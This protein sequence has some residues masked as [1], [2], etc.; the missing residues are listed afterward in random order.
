MPPTTEFTEELRATA[1]AFVS[2]KCNEWITREWDEQGH[3]P[4]SLFEE[5]ASLGWFGI[6]VAEEDGGSGGTAL[7]LIVVCE[8]L[9]RGST[10]LVACLS[11]T[12]SGLRTLV[13]HGTE[14]QKQTLIPRL[15]DGSRRLSI[16]ISEPDAGSDSAAL[17][18][19]AVRR[20]EQ[21]YVVSGQKTWCEAADRP[22]TIIQLFVRTEHTESKH[23]GISMF[24][25]DYDAP[26]V[27]LRR[28]PT[29]GRNITG[30]YEV[31][32]DEV[33]LPVS[34][35]VG[36]EHGAWRMI[37]GELA[38]ERLILGAGFVGATLQVLD[39]VLE[40][41][42][43]REQFGQP[44]GNFQGVAH[45]LVDLYTRA[46]ATRLLVYEGARLHDAGLDC[47]KEASMSKLAGSE[48]YADAVRAAMLLM[49]SYG[50]IREHPLTMHVAD[51]IIAP[52]AGG[53]S[54]IMRNLIARSLGLR[55]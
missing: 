47:V 26:G 32:L 9:G 28:L 8:E 23:Q 35:I 43:Q 12:S 52:V 6:S 1:K 27:D 10:D 44:V 36:P 55:S 53:P 39:G 37:Q 13:S 42:K 46:E 21:T 14:E 51:S 4:V 31:F 34:S 33:E 40:H 22:G 25:L 3:Y 24:L 17:S 19:R 48:L 30:V 20:D 7:D 45:P 29:L 2:A 18:T 11:L 15:M 38:L 41:V 54:Q 16:S 50:Y 5:I 49:G